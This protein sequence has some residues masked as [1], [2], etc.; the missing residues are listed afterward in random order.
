MLRCRAIWRTHP[1]DIL[2]GPRRTCDI[3]PALSD[4][5]TSH[6]RSWQ[7]S[8][9]DIAPLPG[10]HRRIAKAWMEHYVRGMGEDA[11]KIAEKGEA[12]GIGFHG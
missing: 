11:A 5:A 10:R 4:I 2:T 3:A 9:C 6:P 12:I 8:T 7:T 1:R